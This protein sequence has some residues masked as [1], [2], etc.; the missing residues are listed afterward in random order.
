LPEIFVDREYMVPLFC[1]EKDATIKLKLD[2]VQGSKPY[3]LQDKNGKLKFE[4]SNES[5]KISAP[6]KVVAYNDSIDIEIEQK[7]DYGEEFSIEIKAVDNE[8]DFI[9][10]EQEAVCGKIMFSVI[11]RDAF[12]QDEIDALVHENS[13]AQAFNQSG[14]VVG[15]GYCI[16]AADRGLGALLKDT[17]NFYTEPNFRSLGGNGVR[18]K[19]STTRAAV[20]KKLGYVKTAI[21]IETNNYNTNKEPTS[22]ATSLLGKI[23]DTIQNN[24]GY[25]V[26]YFSM[27]GEYHVMLLIVDH[28]DLDPAKIRFSIL[29]QGYVDERNLKF[30]DLD[31]KFVELAQIFWYSKNQHAKNILMWKVKRK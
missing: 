20:I 17:K 6:D 14:N 9:V 28:R 11:Q 1:I 18:L 12:T 3:M 31:K 27:H 2:I 21:T 7:L 5:V 24:V 10:S 16:N 13:L 15:N 30:M 19:S 23:Y 26:Y 8:G 22:L 25:H 4:S 29:D